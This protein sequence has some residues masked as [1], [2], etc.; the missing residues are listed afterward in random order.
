MLKIT[1]EL[2][3]YA[4]KY[5]RACIRD[6]KT[7]FKI[8]FHSRMNN[9]QADF[10]SELRQNSYIPYY[11]N[12]FC[13]DTYRNLKNIITLLPIN[14]YID[15]RFSKTDGTTDLHKNNNLICGCVYVRYFNKNKE[16]INEFLI[17]SVTE[18]NN[19]IVPMIDYKV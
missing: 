10:Q 4:R 12:A 17:E 16:L 6:C 7:Y 18:K 8:E 5:D 19:S 11:Q 1:S 2:K 14:T 13:H 3:K 15:I 9:F